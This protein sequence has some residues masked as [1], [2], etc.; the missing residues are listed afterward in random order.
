[1]FH[2][3]IVSTFEVERVTLLLSCHMGNVSSEKSPSAGFE[4][5]T[6]GAVECLMTN[7]TTG[8]RRAPTHEEIIA[9][10]T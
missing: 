6:Q 8:P 10:K 1:M 4:R 7:K 5:G 3:I 2:I 9:S